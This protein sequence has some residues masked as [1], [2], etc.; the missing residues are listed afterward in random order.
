MF[1]PVADWFAAFLL[2]LAVEAP[3]VALLLR[4]TERSLVRLGVLFVFANLATHLVVWYVLTQLFVVGTVAYVVVAET[5]AIAA[6]AILYAAALRG[7]PVQRAI[8]VAVAANAMS[9][10]AGRLVRNFWPELIG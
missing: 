8:A 2:T 3:V 9:F 4:R 7:V 6:E 5:W 10:L 1:F